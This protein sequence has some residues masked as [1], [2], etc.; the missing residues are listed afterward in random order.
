MEYY[1]DGTILI[2]TIARSD[3]RIICDAEIAQGWQQSVDKYIARIEDN[4]SGRSISM[5]AE[6]KGDV[7]GYINVYPN[8][9]KGAFVGKGYPEIVDF[10]VLERYRRLG[11]GSKLMDIAEEIAGRFSDT[12][13]IGVGL[14]SGY[15]SAQRM[16]C[17]R[18]YIPD[19]SGVWYRNEVAKPY[20]DCCN[21]DDLVLY[22]SKRLPVKKDNGGPTKKSHRI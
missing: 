3:A 6:Y 19:G 18:G 22:L 13:C 7:A 8:P 14:H 21:D 11:I 5:V 12:V 17:K 4:D 2:R 9:T 10:G 20:G 1:N 15:G 16:Y